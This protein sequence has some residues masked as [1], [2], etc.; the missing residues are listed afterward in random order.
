MDKTYA[1]FGYV[2]VSTDNQLEN[3]SI[4]EQIHRITAY[5]K[6]KGWVLIKIYTDGGFS[7]GNMHRPALQQMLDD[8]IKV[9]VDAVIV[10]KLD[11]LSR[12]QKDTLMLI[13]D[14]F[15]SHNV[16]FISIN[17]NFDTSTPFGRAMIGILSVFAQLEK[18]QI[19]ER[20]TMGRIG[21]GKAG[22]FHG[23]G[24]A[25]HGYD[26]VN[27]EL[28]VN[29][30]EAMQI[31]EIYN[32]F[33]QGKSINAITKSMNGKYKNRNWTA[34]AISNALKNT[35]YIGKVHFKGVAYDGK[36]TPIISLDQFNEVQR[37][38]NSQQRQ[39]GKNTAQKSPFRGG[40][41]L[42]SLIYCGRCGARYSAN[43]GYYKCYSRSKSYSK[44]I[45]DPNCRNENWN[46]QELDSIVIETISELLEN[47]EMIQQLILK[48]AYNKN[49]PIVAEKINSRIDTI[50]KQLTKLIEL[51]QVGSLPIEI[52]T[53]K[54]AAL[55]QEKK[56][57]LEQLPSKEG[58]THTL[59]PFIGTISTFETGFKTLDLDAQRLLI[60]TL[61]Q[62]IE[63]NGDNVKLLWRL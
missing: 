55:D 31:E 59:T 51:Y 62:R 22:Y 15:L 13:E 36:H 35:L 45:M 30:Y 8:M 25:P 52:L 40:Y 24:N 23:G 14:Q 27:G 54:A 56:I 44:F 17:E 21:R 19:T 61:I 57:L 34:A 43:H 10:Y 46:I 18:D 37:L 4:E 48:P 60:A 38:L 6:A 42:S 50:N 33:I 32:L 20:F 2:R 9:N 53:D 29:D 28:M 26:Y 63:I 47:K 49:H 12:S 16:D 5:C 3:Y 58:N 1:V 41:L 39:N 11:R 7:G